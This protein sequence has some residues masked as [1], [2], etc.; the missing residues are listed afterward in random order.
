MGPP[1]IQG[2]PGRDGAVGAQG[3]RGEPGAIVTS[4]GGTLT[5]QGSPYGGGVDVAN[6]VGGIAKD[7]DAVVIV[8]C[9]SDGESFSF[10]TGTKTASGTVLT[11]HHVVEDAPDCDV[12]SEAPVRHLGS[13]VEA[14]QHGERDQMELIMEWNDHG[15]A[16]E[17][18]EPFFE[19]LPVLGDFLVIIGHPG[20]GSNLALEHQYTTGYVTSA[21]ASE[22][23]NNLARGAYWSQGYITD[24][25]AWHGNS[26]GPVFN[27][28]GE[29][30][31]LL[32]GSLNGGSSNTGPDLT[33]AIPLL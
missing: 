6:V 4:D 13:V 23:L 8:Q 21:S 31:G 27:E 9:T 19:T 7:A 29:W 11:A 32:V 28:Y 17:G 30:I 5:L 15:A 26:G 12:F 3:P 16:I 1:G 2:E 33:I 10:G 20:V 14:V 22:T 25:V 18:L 24:A